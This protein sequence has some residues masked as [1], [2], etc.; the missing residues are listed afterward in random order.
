MVVGAAAFAVLLAVAMDRAPAPVSAQPSVDAVKTEAAEPAR[1]LVV[2]DGYTVGSEGGGIGPT[3]WTQVLVEGLT[4]E[5]RTV[6]LTVAAAVGAGY[7]QDGEGD[8]TFEE[9]ATQPAEETYDLVVLFGSESDISDSS[10]VEAAA[11]AAYARIRAIWPEAQLLVVGPAWRGSD[12]PASVIR[13]SA[14]VERAAAAA[15]APFLDP[16]DAGWFADD[17]GQLIDAASGYPTD[18]GH[19]VIADQIRPAVQ[20]ALEAQ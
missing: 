11:T 8:Q 18:Q 2:G 3:N 17:S 12:P 15:G 7:L 5:A 4:A 10:A 1:I 20:A 9:L 14:G 16:L 6:E 13:A 19:R